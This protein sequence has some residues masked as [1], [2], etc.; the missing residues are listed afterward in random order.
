MVDEPWRVCGVSEG[1]GDVAL[2]GGGR[3]GEGVVREAGVRDG[4][5]CMAG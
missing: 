2:G 5:V 4:G 3:R 1:L